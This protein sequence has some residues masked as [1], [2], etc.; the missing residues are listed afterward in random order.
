M[1]FTDQNLTFKKLSH[2]DQ[3]PYGLLLLADPSKELVDQYLKKSE[4]FIATVLEETI[5]V[6]VLYPLSNES[7]EIK[8]LAVKPE[9]Q[10]KGVG[11]F[12]IDRIVRIAEQKRQKSIF[13]GTAN[14]SLGQLYLYQK[15]GF[16]IT[17]IRKDFFKD[18]YPEP[19]YENGLQA[20]HL[21]LMKKQLF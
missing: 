16:E 18:N 9:F 14:S 12:L 3:V 2:N 7:S 4:I 1:T 19:I 10:G 8:N 21:V 5:G 17:E 20:K 13:I 6:I 11:S 15:L